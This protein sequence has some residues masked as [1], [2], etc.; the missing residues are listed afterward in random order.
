MYRFVYLQNDEIDPEADQVPDFAGGAGDDH[1]NFDDIAAGEDG[2]GGT[3]QP[4][5]T[6]LDFIPT[7]F[8]G[9]PDRVSFHFKFLIL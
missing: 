6:S 4:L 2:G 9:A 5:N 8:Q 7:E 1:Q 3:N